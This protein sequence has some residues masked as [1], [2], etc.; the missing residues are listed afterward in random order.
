ML[1]LKRKDKEMYY[2]VF[3]EWNYPTESGRELI[4]TY[5]SLIEA[6]ES[7][8][9]VGEQE[10]NNFLDVNKNSLYKEASGF[11]YTF[12]T[13][14]TLDPNIHKKIQ[15]GEYALH[16]S[17]YEDEDMWFRVRIIPVEQ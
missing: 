10:Y 1:N 11:Y 9:R 7:V 2:I 4:D 5:D 3:T 8:K 6:E 17:Q 16:S 15:V 12:G 13:V 14:Y